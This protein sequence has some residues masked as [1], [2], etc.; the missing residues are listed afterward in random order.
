[1]E[2]MRKRGIAC[3]RYFAPVHLQGPYKVEGCSLPVTERVA[4][5]AIALPFFNALSED[6]ID[7]VC[8]A[9][10][11]CIEFTSCSKKAMKSATRL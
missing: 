8:S 3:G 10:R 9:L 6:Q 5:R 4:E 1:V 7:K 2:A 11:E